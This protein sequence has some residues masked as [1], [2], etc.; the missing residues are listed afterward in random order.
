MQ[1]QFEKQRLVLMDEEVL[2]LVFTSYICPD[3]GE[4]RSLVQRLKS[5]SVFCNG[6][7]RMSDV[8]CLEEDLDPEMQRFRGLRYED[9]WISF[10]P[11]F[12]TCLWN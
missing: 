3:V 11:T 5:S 4:A 2:S 7:N 1:Q 8:T 6:V 10:I 12:L 9:L